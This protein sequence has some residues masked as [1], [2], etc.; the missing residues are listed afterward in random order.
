MFGLVI[1]SVPLGAI[2]TGVLATIAACAASEQCLSSTSLSCEPPDPRPAFMPD[3]AFVGHQRVVDAMQTFFFGGVQMPQIGMN[4]GSDAV[5]VLDAY[6][7]RCIPGMREHQVSTSTRVCLPQLAYPSAMV[8]DAMDLSSNISSRRACGRWLDAA[9]ETGVTRNV[10]LG[11]FGVSTMTNAMWDEVAFHVYGDGALL[12]DSAAKLV[13]T[14]RSVVNGGTEELGLASRLAYRELIR[15]AGSFS[16]LDDV[17]GYLGVLVAHA[18][19]GPVELHLVSDALGY[20]AYLR[21]GAMP[22]AQDVERSMRALGIDEVWIESA[23]AD[24]A[25]IASGLAAVEGCA[26]VPETIVVAIVNGIAGEDLSLVSNAQQAVGLAHLGGWFCS[27]EDDVPET[28]FLRATALMSGLAA[29]CVSTLASRVLVE[30][31]GQSSGLS[32][33]VGRTVR[34]LINDPLEVPSVEDWLSATT[35][36]VSRLPSV[37]E[38][39]EG[40]LSAAASAA[41]Q[42]PRDACFELFRYVSVDTAEA[43]LFQALVPPGLYDRLEALVQRVRDAVQAVVVSAP[44]SSIFVD[45]E[46]VAKGVRSSHIRFPGAPMG[47]WAGRRSVAEEAVL[48]HAGGV[49]FNALG[50]LRAQTRDSLRLALGRVADYSPCDIPPLYEATHPNAYYLHETGCIVLFIGLLRAPFVDESFDDASLEGRIGFVIAHEL[51]HN[52]LRSEWNEAPL[53]EL[54][55]AYPSE[56]LYEEALADVIAMHAL[57][58]LTATSRCNATLMHMAQLFCAVPGQTFGPSIHPKGNTRI[59]TLRATMENRL[60][61]G[62]GVG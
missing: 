9:A 16:T 54:L 21:D 36:V 10:G 6:R 60:G 33:S 47:S 28:A 25:L 59:D 56:D 45:A 3:C 44:F 49:L 43:I 17:A 5:A 40:G 57:H 14:C 1:A 8:V 27:L 4:S 62:C 20:T 30:S 35:R 26:A 13:G 42:D 23:V 22:L 29:E 37:G 34:A 24:I 58:Q 39:G 55:G 48:S 2:V 15:S 31:G 53:R 32:A 52:S 18:C 19:P 7:G 11:F 38:G 46:D 61:V 51:A 12:T 50:H 41:S